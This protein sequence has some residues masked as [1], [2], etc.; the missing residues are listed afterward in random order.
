MYSLLDFSVL[1]QTSR[2]PGNVSTRFMLG[3]CQAL[4]YLQRRYNLADFHVNPAVVLSDVEV[5]ILVVHAQVPPLGQLT[6]VPAS[7]HTLR[8]Q[9]VN[10][11][12]K[13][14][15]TA[16]CGL[17][18]RYRTASSRQLRHKHVYTKNLDRLTDSEKVST[19][20]QE[21]M[22]ING[23]NNTNFWCIIQI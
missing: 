23:V 12:K 11:K 21:I 13:P 2:Y 4:N 22:V 9:K 19:W 16:Y 6:F 1:L 10:F 20:G 15:N 17:P 3:L 8:K 5:E 7:D 18:Y 14:S